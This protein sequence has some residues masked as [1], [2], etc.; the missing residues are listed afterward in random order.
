VH[1]LAL[2]V[3]RLADRR[4]AEPGGE[5]IDV[6]VRPLPP[7]RVPARRILTLSLCEGMET[8]GRTLLEADD[9][10][11]SEPAA[12]ESDAQDG[13]CWDRLQGAESAGEQTVDVERGCAC[14]RT[15]HV[16]VPPS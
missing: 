4:L 12:N 14:L 11:F 10:R 9:S 3:A 2:H 16:E 13:S 5:P 15:V 8:E 7:T 1:A 6:V